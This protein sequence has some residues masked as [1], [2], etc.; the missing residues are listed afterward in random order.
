MKNKFQYI[1]TIVL[2]IS[3]VNC[4]HAIKATPY[5]ISK[6]QSDG[7]EITYYLKGDEFFHYKTTLD[8]FLI[9]EDIDG[10]LKYGIHDSKGKVISTGVKANEINKRTAKELKYIKTKLQK[11]DFS[12]ATSQTQSSRIA[13]VKSETSPQ[14]SY[15]LTGSPKSLVILVNFSDKNYIT[16]DPKTAFTNLLNEQGY[17]SNGGT[18]SARDYF[19]DASNG[20]FNPQFD[21][22]GPYTLTKTFA[23]YGE[24][25]SEEDKNPRQLVI[26]ACTL[27][28]AEGVDFAQYDSDNDGFVDNIFIYYA[29]NN[30]AE[31]APAN[32]IWPHRWSLSNYST[33]FDG[34]TIFDYACTSE[35]R[36]AA[37]NNM[38][39]IGTFCHEFGHVLGLP[40]YYITGGTSTHQTPSYWNIMDGGA[41][42][43]LGR[44]PP[45]YSAF[46][47][48]YL[49]WLTPIELKTPQN[50]VLKSL[51]SNNKAY[52]ITQNGNHNLNGSNPS[53]LE[54]FTLE[55]RQ[56]SGW[57][58]YLPGHGLLITRIFYDASTWNSNTP[59]NHEATMGYDIIEADGLAS[60]NNLSGDPFPGVLNVT[61]Y[62]P[63]LRSGA[64]IDKPLT[65]IKETNGVIS[66]RFMGG[67]GQFPT[68]STKNIINNFSTVHGTPSVVQTLIVSGK[69]LV[70][71][72]KIAFSNKI[73]F[74]IKKSTD[75]DN[76]WAKSLILTPNSDSIVTDTEILIRY[77]PTFPSYNDTHADNLNLES[78]DADKVTMTFNGTST[79]PVYVVPPVATEASEVTMGSF[80]ANWNKVQDAS[81]YYLTVYNIS[82]DTSEVRQGFNNGLIEPIGWTISAS[83]ASSSIDYSGKEPPGI[84]FKNTGD[85]IQTE[86]YLFPPASVS[87]FLKSLSGNGGY[88]I[89]EAWNGQVWSK[90]DSVP[91]TNNLAGISRF[92]LNSDK[93]YTRFR[94]SYSKVSG[95]LVVD[96]I[97]ASFTQTNEIILDNQWIITNSDTLINLEND[98]NYFYKVKASD[99][100]YNFNNTIKY[101]NI[102]YFSNLIQV[103]TLK[104]ID[105][106]KLLAV[107]ETDGSV[108]VILPTTD[109]EIYIYN[110]IG[111]KIR[112]IKPVS[113][114]VRITDLPKNQLYILQ[115]GKRK[116]K[117]AL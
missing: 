106:N 72:I 6:T 48:F 65:V 57:D 55:N 23:F 66:F 52:I 115:A 93:N 82:N 54:F 95:Y 1:L 63:K 86:E 100:T 62:S 58:A 83:A 76:S 78:F 103:K 114:I 38:C 107:I 34:K 22:V 51:T 29:G 96:D 117:I 70:D 85:F 67:N 98:K 45:T 110:V 21:V 5:P 49:N 25:V 43:N 27:A 60:D 42:L 99:K 89:V 37:S 73:H 36:G 80:I 4:L 10:I 13:K 101:E 113:N 31:G 74:E 17:S 102:T 9:V 24:N 68:I 15:P 14:K 50:A 109:T 56:Q 16:P 116:T 87:V 64:N 18:G 26:D 8:N 94:F 90:L 71:D 11:V 53:P 77:N 108:K 30:E 32:T 40:D 33:K 81:G 39:G 111:Q 84:Q 3:S 88:L 19:R 28:D 41:Y 20:L 35:L 47:R 59:N 69:K 104:D 7:T 75:A 44:T 105:I 112:V 12:L 46:D 97:T 2:L 61:S 92:N 79:R 91:V